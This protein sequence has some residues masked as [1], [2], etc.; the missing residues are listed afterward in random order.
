GRIRQTT[1][2]PA[3][4]RPPSPPAAGSRNGP[5]LPWS[6]RKAA[7]ISWQ[8]SCMQRRTEEAGIDSLGPGEL[9]LLLAQERHDADRGVRAQGGTGKVLRLDLE[10]FVRPQVVSTTDRVLDHRD[11][12]RRRPRE[13]GGQ[14]FYGGGKAFG[15]DR[16][17]H[18]AG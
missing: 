3:S 9:R 16:P 14:L 4:C 8:P 7:R 5:D 17:I 11:G 2:A 6:L 1:A 12:K 18:P 10:P 15:R 13:P